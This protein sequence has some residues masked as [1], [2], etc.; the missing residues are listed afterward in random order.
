MTPGTVL[1][2]DC[3]ARKTVEI[4]NNG[5]EVGL[6]PCLSPAFCDMFLDDDGVSLVFQDN[7]VQD[8]CGVMYAPATAMD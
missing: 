3:L 5:K 1:Q 6:A 7:I 4:S 8:C 2:F